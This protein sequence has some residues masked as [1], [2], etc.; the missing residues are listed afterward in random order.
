ME[1]VVELQKSRLGEDH[2][3]ALRSMHSLANRYS[4]VGRGDEALNLLEE[5]VK[6]QKSRLGE[7]HLDTLRSMH[8]LAIRYSEAGRWGHPRHRLSSKLWQKFRS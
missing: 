1:K 3:D 5:V 2:P 7:D 6:L 8:R 4:N